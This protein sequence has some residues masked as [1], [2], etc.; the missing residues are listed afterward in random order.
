ENR[1]DPGSLRQSDSILPHEREVGGGSCMSSS[2]LARCPQV[3]GKTNQLGIG[4]PWALQP[5]TFPMMRAWG[6]VFLLVCGPAFAESPCTLPGAEP[7]DEVGDLPRAMDGLSR[8]MLDG[9]HRFLDRKLEES[10]AQ[11]AKLWKR[12][13]SSRAA[14]EKSIEANRESFRKILGV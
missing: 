4:T 3:P 7:L 8:Q 11:R 12:D 10:I 9:L 2:T 5:R 13:T 14:Y 6:F 1:P